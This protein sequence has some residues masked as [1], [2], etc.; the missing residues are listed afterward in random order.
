[1]RSLSRGWQHAV[2]GKDFSPLGFRRPVL[3]GVCFLSQ[4]I[5]LLR[6]LYSASDYIS[7]CW[8]SIFHNN[9]WEHGYIEFLFLQC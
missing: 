6:W 1:M 4:Q 9:W 5:F 7:D 3:T 2:V 8:D